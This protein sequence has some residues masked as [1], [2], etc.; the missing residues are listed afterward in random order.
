MTTP[1][2]SPSRLAIAIPLLFGILVAGCGEETPSGPPSGSG[3]LY[4]INARVFGENFA[5]TS[6]L[7]LVGD[8]ESGTATLDQA[9]EIP[10]G[11]SLWGAP[12]SGELYFVSAE[13]LTVT[14]L[15]LGS[16]GRLEE[17]GRLGLA[18]AGV[19]R[20]LTEALTV[21]GDGRG[22]LFD[23]GSAQALELDLGA[24]EIRDTHDLSPMLIAQ[25]EVTLLAEGGF[26]PRGDVLVGTA[27]GTT[28]PFDRVSS[29]AKVG[30]FDPATGALEVI[31]APCGGLIYSF[32]VA[33]GEWYFSTDPWVAG[34]HALDP[35]RAP[36]P[37]LA[38]LPAGSR[39]FDPATVALNDLTGGVTGGLVPSSDG[40]VFV[41]VLDQ[42]L[43]PLTPQT[44]FLAPF[45]APA[46]QTWRLDLGQP[47][48]AE[49]LQRPP[50][51]G[52]IKF[53][54]V[55]GKTYQNESSADFG[56]TTL[57]RTTGPDA[58]APG[59]MVPGV[60]WNIVRVR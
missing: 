44:D 6:Y 45:S 53:A 49:R 40:R 58:P 15:R 28:G 23:I 8:L 41:R 34:I 24:M 37:C 36:A 16:S 50:I 5:P 7:V 29:V 48:S 12:A 9:L 21:V 57:V 55:D 60:A 13:A 25:A 20:V 17:A 1:S 11:G 26:R 30:F 19:S 38:R 18:G 39:T 3:P 32:E 42:S 33:G 22:F 59:L 51:A 56:A 27:Y 47:P 4:A 35:S 46:W 54:V 43:F 31:E 2:E 52:G 14:K 10:G